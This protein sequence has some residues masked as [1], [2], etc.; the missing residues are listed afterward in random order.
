MSVATADN[1][2]EEAVVFYRDEA[3]AG[4]AQA[5]AA[6]VGA[7]EARQSDEYDAAITLVAV[8]EPG[9]AGAEG[10]AGGDGEG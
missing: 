7:G 8:A 2:Q 6:E 3:D 10:D 9:D 1:H 5:L 4:T